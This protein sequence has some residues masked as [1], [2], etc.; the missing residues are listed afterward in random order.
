[1]LSLV[2]DGGTVHCGNRRQTADNSE[3]RDNAVSGEAHAGHGQR[4]GPMQIQ[5]SCMWEH[6]SYT[7]TLPVGPVFQETDES[8]RSA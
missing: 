4:R 3:M 6:P 2:K 8:I 7:G 1:L 5:I